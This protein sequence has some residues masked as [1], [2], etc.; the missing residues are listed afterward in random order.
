MGRIYRITNLTN[1]KS[2]V[3]FTQGSIT[4]RFAK[5]IAASKTGIKSYLHRAIRKDGPQSFMV[6]LLQEDADLNIDESRWISELKPEYNMTSGGEG[7]DTSSSP[8]FKDGVA[9]YHAR[10]PRSEYATCGHAGKKHSV[11]TKTAQSNTRKAWWA[12]LTDEERETHL[13]NFKR[14]QD[15][16]MFGRSPG[17]AKPVTIEGVTYPSANKACAALNVKSIYFLKKQYTIE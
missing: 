16:P 15:N 11:T 10:K 3:G 1:G 8:N 12:S 13:S 2:Y 17:N 6:E 5:H 4:A 7:G 14:G 9:A